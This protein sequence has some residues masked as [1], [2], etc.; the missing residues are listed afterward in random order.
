MA[1]VV[2]ASIP[3]QPDQPRE[4]I[5]V[6]KQEIH[7]TFYSHEQQKRVGFRQPS[8]VSSQAVVSKHTYGSPERGKQ[9]ILNFNDGNN[10]DFMSKF[11]Q[12][13]GGAPLRD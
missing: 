8:Q 5:F 6:P 11:G 3:Q 12:G 10:N 9:N 1:S 13:G 4:Q 2:T 7:R